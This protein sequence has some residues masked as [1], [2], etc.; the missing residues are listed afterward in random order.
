VQTKRSKEG[1][2]LNCSMGQSPMFFPSKKEAK[3]AISTQKKQ[4]NGK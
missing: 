1:S 2:W 4:S 3:E